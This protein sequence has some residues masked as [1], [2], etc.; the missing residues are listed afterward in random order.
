MEIKTL[1]EDFIAKEQ[2]LLQL[3]E[4]NKDEDMK[5][6]LQEL[7]CMKISHEKFIEELKQSFA[8]DMEDVKLEFD[9]R[10]VNYEEKLQETSK[11][12]EKYKDEAR[13]LEESLLSD[14]DKRMQDVN[15]RIANYKKDN[16]SLKVV[17]ELKNTEIHELRVKCQVLE[18]ELEKYRMLKSKVVVLEQKNIELKEALELKKSAERRL[19]QRQLE[20]QQTC[21]RERDRAQRLC[22]TNEQL[23]YR[24]QSVLMSQSAYE[25]PMSRFP[26]DELSKSCLATSTLDVFGDCSSTFSNTSMEHSAT[27]PP[28]AMTQS[29]IQ[30]YANNSPRSSHSKRVPVKVYTKEGIVSSLCFDKSCDGKSSQKRRSASEKA[31]SSHRDSGADD[32]SPYR[33]TSARS[34]ALSTTDKRS[35]LAPN[36]RRISPF[37]SPGPRGPEGQ[38]LGPSGLPGVETVIEETTSCS[39]ESRSCQH[40]SENVTISGVV[41]DSTSVVARPSPSKDRNDDPKMREKRHSNYGGVFYLTDSG[42]FT[43]SLH[44]SQENFTKLSCGENAQSSK[45]NDSRNS[46]LD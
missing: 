36:K 35:T 19:S 13:K 33:P 27:V 44:S 41:D 3:N 38:A 10:K 31:A 16:E 18:K 30:I 26:S 43:S 12:A 11:L 29:L 42:V 15:E 7:S 45:N 21:E 4:T 9:L 14:V 32:C 22:M 46:T 6:H 24:L 1:V 34:D 2:K 25:T 17:V 37:R 28:S 23:Q 20:L 40:S 8:K 5:H 39:T